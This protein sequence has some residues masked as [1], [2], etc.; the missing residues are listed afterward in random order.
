[1]TQA[2]AAVAAQENIIPGLDLGPYLAGEP[3]AIDT[4]AQQLRHTCENVGFFYIEN[5]G[6]S[7]A[8]I[9]R[10]FAASKRIHAA[11][12]EVK[13]EIE[14]NAQN[15]GYM[16]VNESIQG[17]SKVEKA[18]KPNYNESFFCMRDR[19]PDDPD[20]IANKPYKGLNQ[21]PR[22]LPGFREDTLAYMYAV[23]ALGMK[24]LPVVARSLDLPL[25]FFSDYFNPANLQLRLLHYPIRDESEP[26]QYGAGAH[27]DAG[28]LT[29][30]MQ[31]DI[32][33]LQIRRTDGEWF[34][35]PVLPGRFLIN[36]GD[37]F[38]RWTND[39]YLS[40][41]H[42]VMNVSGTD[43]YSIAFFFGPDLD[44]RLSC[45]PTCQSPDNP[46]KYEPISYGEYKTA[47]VG[48]NYFG[49]KAKGSTT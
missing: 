12:V 45:L 31:R 20:V 10:T 13:R 4:L 32:G 26:E 41:P 16:F 14:L 46:A 43:R 33:G 27:T 15:I 23:E 18:K 47:F 21:W 28:F 3:G 42:R 34:D 9:D 38:R 29:F 25:D 24:M 22:N 6:I 39:R 7:Q 2:V 35:A 37:I 5:H 49:R 30:L 48:A 44:R 8:L 11:P 17:A 40:T 36:T 19:T 1:M